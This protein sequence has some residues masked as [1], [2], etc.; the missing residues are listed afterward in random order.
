MG[1]FLYYALA[2]Y[3][4]SL[5]SLVSITAQQSN[6]T[7]QTMQQLKQFLDY[8]DTH[9]YA[10]ITYH[11]SDMVLAYHSDTSY[12]FKTKSRSKAGGNFF[13]SKKR[14]SLPTM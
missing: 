10:I 5:T 2:I 1:T 8:A 4:T 13:M 7:E 12:L 6:P 11:A 9:T 14:S 3:P